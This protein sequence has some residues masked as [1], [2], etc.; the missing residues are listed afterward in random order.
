MRRLPERANLAAVARSIGQ[1]YRQ[2]LSAALFDT[3]DLT[4]TDANIPVRM[5]KCSTTPSAP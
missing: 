3:G 5:T 1:P 4:D 2:I